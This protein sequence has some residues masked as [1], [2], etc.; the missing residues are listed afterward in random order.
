MDRKVS[1]NPNIEVLIMY[2]WTLAY[3]EARRSEWMEIRADRLR[4]LKRIEVTNKI[5]SP[6][7]NEE[8]R[9]KVLNRRR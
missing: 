4:F 2:E 7:L 6:I 5:L 9:K 1:F 8:H 3:T